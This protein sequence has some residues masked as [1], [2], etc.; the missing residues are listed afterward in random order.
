MMGDLKKRASFARLV[1]YVNNPKKAR[2][3]DSKDVRLDDNATIARSMQG[4]AD[5][6][7]GRKLKNP[8]YHISLDFAH[9]DALRLTDDL[10]VEIAREYMR[11]MGITN[12]QYIVCRHTDREHQHLHIVANRVNNDGKTISDSNDDVRNI[13]VCKALTREYGL[14][15]SKGKM[16]VKRDRLRGK[17]KVKYQIYD[18][19]KAAL[20][21]CNNW[22][23]LCDKLAKQGIGVNFK[24]NRNEGKIIGVSFTKNEISFS[25]SRID[26]SMSFYKLDRLFGNRIAEGI[27]WQPGVPDNGFDG[28]TRPIRQDVASDS[29]TASIFIGQSL[30]TGTE[31]DGNGGNPPE[32]GSNIVQVTIEALMELCVQP[33]QAK[34]SSGGGGGGNESG[35]DD[36]DN[37]KDKLKPR[38]RRR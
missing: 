34:M 15:F 6:K 28:R 7:P 30:P 20:P 22:S 35:W 12:T 9:E 24:Y 10:M 8:V 1:N 25:G 37:E 27:E 18:A 29:H 21:R 16:N 13:K 19:I 5:D 26:R 11:R 2:L 17:D 23:D 14:H 38:R 4:Q 36:N 33:H 31:A 3:I 32:S